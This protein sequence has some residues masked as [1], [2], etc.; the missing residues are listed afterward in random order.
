[1]AAQVKPIPD[2]YHTVT[3]YLIVTDAARLIDFYRQALGA[4]KLLRMPGPGGSVMHAEIRIGDSI[5]MLGDEPPDKA[6]CR[7]PRSAGARTASLYLYVPDVD[8]SFQRA[9]AAGARVVT[10]PTD[11]FWGDRIG[12]I[13]DPAGHQWTLATHKED[14]PAEE[15]ARRHQA[16][17][18]SMEEKKRG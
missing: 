17:V 12:T 10:E 9:A 5:V 15:I 16:F 4:Q 6:D 13:E 18:A 14:L 11:M 8:R 7:S 1:M 2:G 3:P